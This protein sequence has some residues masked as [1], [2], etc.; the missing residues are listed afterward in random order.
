MAFAGDFF[1]S[2]FEITPLFARVK[3]GTTISGGF[4]VRPKIFVVAAL[5]AVVRLGKIRNE[6]TGAV[7][8]DLVVVITGVRLAR[9]DRA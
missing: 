7:I 9:I 3:G 5:L 1:G 8:C 4:E 2:F 6:L